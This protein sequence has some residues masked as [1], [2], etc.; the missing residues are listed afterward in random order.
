MAKR[1][2]TR[3][4]DAVERVVLDNG[5]RVLIKE[6]HAAPVATLWAWYGVGSRNER[7]GITGASHWVEHMLFKGTDGFGKGEIMRQVS[8]LGG[9]L[10]GFTSEDHT[11]YFETLPREHLELAARIES[12]RMVNAR[13]AADEVAA[14]RTVILSERSMAEN[15]PGFLL[16]EELQAAAFRIHPYRWH[17]LGWRGDLEA[18]TREDLFAHYQTYYTPQNCVLVVV[19]DFAGAEALE[20]V[21]RYF[22]GIAPGP[23]PSPPRTQEPAQSGER[24][25]TLHKPGAAARVH[26]AH[27]IPQIGHPDLPALIVCDAI[28]GGAKPV[29]FGSGVFLGRSSRLYRALVEGGLASSAG[30][31]LAPG[32]DPGLFHF[33]LMVRDGVRPQEAEARLVQEIERM[34]AEP[35]EP[36][37][38]E[39]AVRQARAQYAYGADGVSSQASALGYYESA[40][41]YRYLADTLEAVAQVT[42]EQVRAAA[43]KYLSPDNRTIG[44]FEPTAPAPE[45]APNDVNVAMLYRVT[46]R[47]AFRSGGRTRARRAPALPQIEDFALEAGGRLLV[48]ENRTSPAVVVR[49]SLKAGGALETDD[50]AGLAHF[51]AAM[52]RRGAGKRSSDEIAE[53]V[54]SVGGQISFWSSAERVAFA[55]K[56]LAQDLPL[57]LQVLADCLRLPTFPPEQVELVRGEMVTALK[58]ELD[59]TR[60]MADQDLHELAYPAGHPYHRNPAGRL[61]T[62]PRLSRD[63]LA[64]FHARSYGPR[65]MITAVVG[66]VRATEVVGL[67]RRCF[68]DWEA[69]G[70]SDFEIPPIN[71]QPDGAQRVRTM[72]HKSQ[73]DIALGYLALSRKDDDFMPLN[74]ADNILGRLGLMGRLGS[75][76]RDDQGLAYYVFSSVEA[77]IGRGLWRLRAGVAPGD[78]DRALESMHRELNR[79][80]REPPPADELADA[81]R[82]QIGG[83]ALRLETNEGVA[84]AI[85]DIAY[86]DLG[87]DYLERYPRLLEAITAQRVTEVAARCSDPRESALAIAGPYEE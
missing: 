61:D 24:R 2:A 11:V 46:A 8:R 56:G 12:D 31:Y 9:Y 57:L 52:L 22:G 80:R 3:I 59:D 41:G 60:A 86:W 67:M 18:M 34:R 71:H 77:C 68:G 23:Q 87:L 48:S 21:R 72:S 83:L 76:V 45:A 85:H 69:P 36:A 54:E 1:T 84:D 37:E 30:C 66:D 20:L 40:V 33:R 44:I 15:D 78:V 70:P 5:L 49:G 32:V 47:P 64:A 29:S 65:T 16:Q 50:T 62:V 25:V 74:L 63:D 51:T 4:A 6:L 27:H 7:P 82:N 39:K 58:D 19:G 10:N 79:L 81:K 53:L 43:E 55:A 28:L 75:T 35:P 17:V 42:A 26:V 38:V 13:F 14:E 73:V